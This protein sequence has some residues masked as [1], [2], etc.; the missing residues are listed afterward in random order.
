LQ[1]L[2]RGAAVI[3]PPSTVVN[4]PVVQRASAGSRK[5]L[6]H[7]VCGHLMAECRHLVADR[8]VADAIG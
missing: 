1:A 7:V 8:A 6:R 5:L 4:E 2:C 3:L